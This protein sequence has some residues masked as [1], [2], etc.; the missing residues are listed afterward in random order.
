MTANPNIDDGRDSR[1]INW[2][3]DPTT[4]RAQ[5]VVAREKAMREWQWLAVT[6]ELE[7]REGTRKCFAIPATFTR[8]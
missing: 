3:R 8:R 7:R 5:L 4:T 1:F 2:L 6:R